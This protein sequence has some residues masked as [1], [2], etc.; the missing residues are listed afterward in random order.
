[1]AVRSRSTDASG[2]TSELNL[3]NVKVRPQPDALFIVP[4][5]YQ[6]LQRNGAR[7]APQEGKK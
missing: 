2:A 5:D 3:T 1:M 6:F 4:K 7:G